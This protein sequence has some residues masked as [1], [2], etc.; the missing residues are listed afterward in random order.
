M[1]FDQGYICKFVCI[2]KKY[3]GLVIKQSLAGLQ[4][5]CFFISCNCRMLV[6]RRA[7]QK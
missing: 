2:K 7:V 1:V 6:K 5:S 3:G 4:S